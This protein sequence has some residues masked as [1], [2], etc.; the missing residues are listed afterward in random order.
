MLKEAE[1]YRQQGLLR[2]TVEQYRKVENIIRSSDGV[3]NK[4][5]LLEKINNRIEAI[6]R[7]IRE[8]SLPASKKTIAV[9]VPAPGFGTSLMPN[10]SRVLLAL[11]GKTGQGASVELNIL[12]Q[13][14]DKITVLVSQNETAL[15]ECL[16]AGVR[17]D[18]AFFYSPAASFSGSMHVLLH[19]KIDFGPQTGDAR[20]HMKI[21]DISNRTAL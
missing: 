12:Y 21:I 14:N 18:G 10:I 3:K 5:S 8:S 16:Q 17:I 11:P 9:D 4:D 20:V 6:G 15:I 13:H 1:S 19:T 7:E 2:E